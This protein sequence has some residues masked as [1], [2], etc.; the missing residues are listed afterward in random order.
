MTVHTRSIMSIIRATEVRAAVSAARSHTPPHP[1]DPTHSLTPACMRWLPCPSGG[2]TDARGGKTDH[3]TLAAPPR[4]LSARMCLGATEGSSRGLALVKCSR[5]APGHQ[6]CTR[7]V[8]AC[9]HRC[10]VGSALLAD[11]LKATPSLAHAAS[12]VAGR[13][14]A[15][16]PHS[17]RLLLPLQDIVMHQLQGPTRH[18]ELYLRVHKPIRRLPDGRPGLVCTAVDHA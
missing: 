8:A 3:Y 18:P 11:R 16:W 6:V 2:G 4:L 10:R 7:N 13:R 9:T 17:A 1:T 14:G 12:A 5:A 15:A